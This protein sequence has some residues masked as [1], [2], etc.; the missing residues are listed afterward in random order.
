MIIQIN[1]RLSNVIKVEFKIKKEEMLLG[2]D[3]K[4]KDLFLIFRVV[5]G[6][7]WSL[8]RGIRIRKE[9]RL[10]GWEALIKAK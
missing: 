9:R 5:V 7:N 1:N 4:I 10:V 3:K 6:L 2:K 8:F